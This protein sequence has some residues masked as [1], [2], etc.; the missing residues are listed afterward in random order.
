[1]AKRKRIMYLFYLP[2]LCIIL[3]F[4]ARPLAETLYI[5]F[6]QW[7]GYSSTKKFIGIKNYLDIFRD[8]HFKT[9]FIN[10]LIYGVMSTLLQNIIG[11][12]SAFFVNSRFK[13]NGIVRVVIYLPIMI[14]GLVM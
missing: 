11:M 9:V 6:C 12:A 2:A 8:S 7:N 10:T 1:M 5:S 3:I 14:S 13:G 4:I